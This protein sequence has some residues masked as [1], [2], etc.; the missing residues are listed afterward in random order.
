MDLSNRPSNSGC[1]PGGSNGGGPSGGDPNGGGPNG[2][3]PNGVDP[4]GGDPN[5]GG[6]NGAGPSCDDGLGPTVPDDGQPRPLPSSL[7]R[8]LAALSTPRL[9]DNLAP[10]LVEQLPSEGKFHVI[11]SLMFM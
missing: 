10:G 1:N 8:S 3:D 5:G 6:P 9:P 2:G 4:N 7:A 11:S